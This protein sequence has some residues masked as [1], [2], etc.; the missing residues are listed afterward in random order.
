MRIPCFDAEFA[1]S[2]SACER[3]AAL[4][5]FWDIYPLISPPLLLIFCVVPAD[6][7]PVAPSS[8]SFSLDDIWAGDLRYT[9]PVTD[10]YVVDSRDRPKVRL[11]AY[12]WLSVCSYTARPSSRA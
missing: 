7:D 4:G 11:F 8:D 9:L 5:P 2:I 6:K 10:A 12:T 3:T 1:V